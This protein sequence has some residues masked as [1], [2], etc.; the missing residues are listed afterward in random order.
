METTNQNKRMPVPAL[1][2]VWGLAL[3]GGTLGSVVIG[4]VGVLSVMNSYP[5]VEFEQGAAF[6]GAFCGSVF[7]IPTGIFAGGAVG[8]LIYNF[9]SKRNSLRPIVVAS[10]AAF[11][12][13][14]VISGL[15]LI[16]LGIVF[17]GLGHI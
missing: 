11:V 14:T 15:T 17:F 7:S 5:G 4:I 13:A 9:L 8:V 3:L 16:P 10:V 12:I 1:L 6:V 2:A